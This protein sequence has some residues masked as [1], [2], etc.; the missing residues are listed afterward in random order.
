MNFENIKLEFDAVIAHS[1]G[2]PCPQTEDLFNQW[3]KN[4]ERFMRLFGGLR[5]CLGEVSLSLSDEVKAKRIVDLLDEIDN[6]NGN[7]RLM[8]FIQRNADNFFDNITLEDYEIRD[9]WSNEVE[10]IVPKGMKIIKAFKMFETGERLTYFQDYASRIIQEDKVTGKLY[11]SVHPL[12]YLSASMNNHNWR[13]CHA[14][15]G[16]YRSGNLS[17]MGDKTTIISYITTD[18]LEVLPLFPSNVLWNSKKWRMWLYVSEEEDLVFAGKPYPFPSEEVLEK[19]RKSDFFNN[20]YEW[21][22]W[23][24]QYVDEEIVPVSSKYL[25][26][27]AKLYDLADVVK[28]NSNEDALHFNDV[29]RSCTYIYPN[30]MIRRNYGWARHMFETPLITVGSDVKCLHC[31]ERYID[32]SETMRCNKCELEYGHEEN[33]KYGRCDSCGNRMVRDESHYLENGDHV[34][35]TCFDRYCFICERCGEMYYNSERVFDD[36]LEQ[37]ICKACKIEREEN[38][39]NGY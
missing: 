32:D 36:T 22:S 20:A 30:Y 35:L 9:P 31:G 12:D 15:D 6:V 29:L 4:K 33:D 1:Q 10:K 25:P 2:I 13:S 3:Y 27:R 7:W 34:C 28:E 11:L 38:S 16:E 39:K 37:Y 26:I 17:Y 18:N 23:S 24:H 5:M 19:I 21:S 8:D 14:L